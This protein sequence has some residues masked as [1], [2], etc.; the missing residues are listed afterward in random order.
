M[1]YPIITT[2]QI[3]SDS[4]DNEIGVVKEGV[5]KPIDT[6]LINSE[7]EDNTSDN[8]D[9]VKEGGVNCVSTLKLYNLEQNSYP[10]P[11]PS[12]TRSLNSCYSP[13]FNCT[14][15]C[16]PGCSTTPS[17]TPRPSQSPR[18]S[19][20]PSP[21]PRPSPSPSFNYS[22]S[23]S[24]NFS[25]Y[26]SSSNNS[27]RTPTPNSLRSTNYSPTSSDISDTCD[28]NDTI[29]KNFIQIIVWGLESFCFLLF[30]I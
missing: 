11:R 19:P 7:S 6:I 29:I 27:S 23:P 3:S 2:I 17:L 25:C 30:T 18:C 16:S 1:A 4:E 20:T 14:P 22:C 12:P 21:T 9:V 13:N 24:A 5:E 8:E 28:G 15:S 26:S 10:S